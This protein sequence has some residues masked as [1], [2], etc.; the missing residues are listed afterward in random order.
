MSLVVP[1][2][3]GVLVSRNQTAVPPITEADFC[4]RLSL[5]GRRSGLRVLAFTAEGVS[6]ENHSIRGYA[7]RDGV[8]ASGRFPLP[9]I[10]YNRCFHVH[11]SQHVGHKLKDMA[12][13]KSRKLL[14]WS[15][16]LP[17]KWQVYRALHAVDEVRPF[18][19]PTAPYRDTAQLAEWLRRHSRLF[20][21]PQA[22]THGKGTLYL[23]LTEGERRLLV[24]G[25]DSRNRPFRRLFSELDAGLTWINGIAHKRA[26]IVQPYLKLTSQSGRP[27]DVRALLQKDGHGLWC[28]TGFAVREGR[29]GTLTSNLHGGG[30]AHPAEPYLREQF[31]VDGTRLIMEQMLKLSL[32]IT[33]AL[34]ER[35]GRLGELGIDYGI[36]RDGNIWLLEVNSRPGRASFFQIRQPECAFRSINRPLEYAR[37][38][39]TQSKATGPQGA[40]ASL[41]HTV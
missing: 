21:K 19:P 7:Y 36:D 16:N 39:M 34:E 2:T 31:G 9:D 15:R 13:Q 28:L 24:R 6:P 4:R 1:G 14:Y 38:L 41:E 18:V 32:T 35:Y 3:L 40:G 25:R 26:Y 27:F 20:M 23:H 37:Y 8:W 12:K 33:G 29:K 30:K 11:E 5:L 22:G 10:V 17:G